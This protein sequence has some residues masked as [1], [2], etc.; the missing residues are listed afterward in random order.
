[1]SA[2]YK[3]KVLEYVKAHMSSSQFDASHDW[4]HI[5]RV[6]CR[7]LAILAVESSR[8]DAPAYNEEVVYL[9]AL[10]HDVVDHKYVDAGSGE[11]LANKVSRVLQERGVD[12]ELAEAVQVVCKNVSYSNETKNKA[13]V[14]AALKE[15][16][17]L[18]IVQDA[19][20]LDA[21]GAV[22]I[23]RVFAFTGA[24]SARGKARTLEGSIEHFKEKL[25][26]VHEHMKT[27]E[28]RR[29]AQDMTARLHEFRKWFADETAVTASGCTF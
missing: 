5:E 9:A 7:A 19:D 3:E 16:P 13:E 24:T 2:A 25:E 4:S 12:A 1:M 28:G 21:I 11:D 10:M 17:E 15:H 14:L 22:G 18:G 23:A 20:R 8:P 29:L 26:L 27:Q 6:L